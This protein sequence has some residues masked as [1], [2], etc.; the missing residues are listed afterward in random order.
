MG[1]IPV[2]ETPSTLYQCRQDLSSFGLPH[3]QRHSDTTFGIQ[4][5]SFTP[6]SHLRVLRSPTC[7]KLPLQ[8]CFF[9]Y[10]RTVQ[11]VVDMLLMCSRLVS[12]TGILVL[13][14]V[15]PSASTACKKSAIWMWL[16]VN[17]YL[18]VADYCQRIARLMCSRMQTDITQ[19]HRGVSYLSPKGSNACL[20]KYHKDE[21][22]VGALV[23]EFADAFW[24]QQYRSCSIFN[25][26]LIPGS[27]YSSI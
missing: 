24:A 10:A 22:C 21:V 2:A 13:L 1:A 5:S 14:V 7:R 11:A 25:W 4:A 8:V 23:L 18:D 27:I 9:R 19:C 12:E 26:F 20:E 17:A 16:P 6:S 15:Q 3:A